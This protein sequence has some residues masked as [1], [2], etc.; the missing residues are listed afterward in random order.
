VGGRVAGTSEAAGKQQGDGGREHGAKQD[1]FFLRTKMAV[2]LN[3]LGSK[4]KRQKA[5]WATMIRQTFSRILDP[6]RSIYR[7]W[8][9]IPAL[10]RKYR[11]LSLA[12][13]FRDI[14]TAARWGERTFCSGRG[15]D[16]SISRPYCQAVVE[17]MRMHELESVVDLGC[18]DFRVGRQIAASGCV[19]IG[20][21]V[22]A[23]LVQSNQLRYGSKRIQF[24]C[25]DI[26]RPG[27]FPM[28]DLCLV[29][30]VFQHLSNSE[31]AA[32]LENLRSYPYVL[33]TEHQPLRACK[34]N[35]D[36]IHG[37]DTRVSVHSGVY[38]GEA[39]FSLPV[40]PFVETPCGNDEV[41]RT[42]LIRKVSS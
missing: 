37:P 15:S 3:S 12:E 38:L 29:R 8:V 35:V 30:Q 17:F 10:H 22:V 21:D 7:Q 20:V 27:E 31:I 26:T 41:L 28:A 42:I 2:G 11:S 40:S 19:Y 24:K 18:G 39:P 32:A 23:E 6:L 1:W 4:A 25:L 34:Y 5:V 13:A 33:V 16:N 14:Y 9:V 36:K